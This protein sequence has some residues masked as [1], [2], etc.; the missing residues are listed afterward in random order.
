MGKKCLEVD[1]STNKIVFRK[2]DVNEVKQKWK[3]G[4]HFED[5]LRNW[6]NVGAKLL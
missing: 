5:N 1:S 6:E 2:C 3:W 4:K